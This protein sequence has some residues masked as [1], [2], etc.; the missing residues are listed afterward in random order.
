MSS[1]CSAAGLLEDLSRRPRDHGRHFLRMR[2]KDNMARPRDLGELA[3]CALVIETLQIGADDLVVVSDD[4][5]ARLGLPG[6]GGQR[7]G[8]HA[9]GRKDLRTRGKFGV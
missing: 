5:S 3:A 9:A 4:A 8:K 6:G 1:S 7:R 2:L